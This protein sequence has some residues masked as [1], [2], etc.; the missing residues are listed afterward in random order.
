MSEKNESLLTTWSQ[1][2][3]NEADHALLEQVIHTLNEHYDLMN[4]FEREPGTKAIIEQLLGRLVQAFGG[5]SVLTGKRVLDIACGS[6]SSQ[7]PPTL[8]INTPLQTTIIHNNIGNSYT[9][10]F[11]PWF[12][13]ILLA[14]AADPVG[15]DF[16]D[17]SGETFE[18]YHV[19][20]SQPSALDFLPSHSFDALQ[21]SRLFGSPEFTTQ[22]PHKAD[23]L[24]VALEIR[25]QEQRLLKKGG[26]IIHSDTITFIER[27]LGK[28]G[29]FPT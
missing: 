22:L 21:D 2:V 14:L 18:H 13:R 9:A 3:S 25:S 4:K 28:D 27:E 6:N 19:D 8:N 5:L 26:I 15:I 16:G 24:K 12:C 23:R 7:T 20:L 11:E 17:L 29:R 1:L 10:Q